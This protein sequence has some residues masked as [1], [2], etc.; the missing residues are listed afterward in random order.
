MCNC[1]D[2]YRFYQIQLGDQINTVAESLDIPATLLHMAVPCGQNGG[3]IQGME[4]QWGNYEPPMAICIPQ[5]EIEEIIIEIPI[6]LEDENY[7]SNVPLYSFHN[8]DQFL[9]YMWRQVWRENA[10]YSQADAESKLRNDLRSGQNLDYLSFY[11]YLFQSEYGPDLAV[12]T[13]KWFDPYEY[14]T[15]RVNL[16]VDDPTIDI[17]TYEW[18]EPDLAVKNWLWYQRGGDAT[19]LDEDDMADFVADDLL[20]WRLADLL[21]NTGYSFDE[22]GFGLPSRDR[23]AIEAAIEDHLGRDYTPDDVLALS[24]EVLGYLEETDQ[25]QIG[26]S[27]AGSVA[28]SFYNLLSSYAEARQIDLIRQMFTDPDWNPDADRAYLDNLQTAIDGMPEEIIGVSVAWVKQAFQKHHDDS[29]AWQNYLLELYANFALS[30][31]A[32]SVE[33]SEIGSDAGIPSWWIELPLSILFEPVDWVLSFRDLMN[34]DPLALIGFLPLIPGISRYADEVVDAFRYSDEMY[35]VTRTYTTDFMEI[36]SPPSSR[37][38]TEEEFNALAD[39]YNT[40]FPNVIMS[41]T[42]HKGMD[43]GPLTNVFANGQISVHFFP[44]PY[45]PTLYDVAHE[46]SHVQHAQI[47]GHINYR[48]LD[49]QFIGIVDQ[50][51]NES[52]IGRYLREL[53]VYRNLNSS[54]GVIITRNLT[55]IPSSDEIAHSR[56]LIV[57]YRTKHNIP[58]AK[59]VLE[60]LDDFEKLYDVNLRITRELVEDSFGW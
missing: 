23:D 31:E 32:L 46:V 1:P 24:M 28:S 15:Y 13:Y 26:E 45:L 18:F 43:P 55:F 57:Y 27:E 2:G 14:V 10:I 25:F 35:D 41:L 47:I 29:L 6:P 4:V 30:E 51:Y 34:G 38:L 11:F 44:E 17:G 33:A 19:G 52:L 36:P 22:L 60:F 48:Y 21:A 50:K 58:D 12:E 3:I 9:Q 16:P 56:N 40:E 8:S 7:L 5:P 39:A 49:P 37:R 42:A 20:L 59:S 54:E 53:Y